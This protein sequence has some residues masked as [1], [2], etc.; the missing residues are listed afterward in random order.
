[1]EQFSYHTECAVRFATKTCASIIT[2]T[3]RLTKLITVAVVCS[4]LSSF[5]IVG[6]MATDYNA[7]PIAASPP[8]KRH[9]PVTS[10]IPLLHEHHHYRNRLPCSLRNNNTRVE[11]ALEPQVELLKNGNWRVVILS[12]LE[13][14]E[15]FATLNFWPPESVLW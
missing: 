7:N 3:S 15:T 5:N 9:R 2:D 14:L 10:H 11:K 8:P 1:M 12:C 4:R 6:A 13:G